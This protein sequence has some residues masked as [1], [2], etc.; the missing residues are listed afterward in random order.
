MRKI[1]KMKLILNGCQIACIFRALITQHNILLYS[2]QWH[3]NIRSDARECA[4]QREWEIELARLYVRH[5]LTQNVLHWSKKIREYISLHFT[6]QLFVFLLYICVQLWHV[7]CA[8]APHKN[9]PEPSLIFFFTL[10]KKRY[11]NKQ[12]I[13][14]FLFFSYSLLLLVS[15]LFVLFYLRNTAHEHNVLV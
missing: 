7:H 12:R 3:C 10:V 14:F 6:L 15:L 8:M 9:C 11:F 5:K 13:S 2:V 1:Q 4:L